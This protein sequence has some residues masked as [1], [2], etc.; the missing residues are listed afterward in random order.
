MLVLLIQEMKLTGCRIAVESPVRMV[1]SG[2]VPDLQRIAGTNDAIH[3][4]DESP[5]EIKGSMWLL[6]I[7]CE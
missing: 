2:G 4:D 5:K 6:W 1:C 3:C 7:G